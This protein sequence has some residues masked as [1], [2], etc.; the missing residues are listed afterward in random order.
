M[1][2]HLLT[3]LTLEKKKIE[4]EHFGHKSV[5]L[6]ATKLQG[7]TKVW[8]N[9]IVRERADKGKN[10]IPQWHK[11]RTSFLHASYQHDLFARVQR[12]R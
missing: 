9:N 12:L 10:V 5:K 1:R 4:H 11:M 7:L 8:W 6:V 2:M 3:G